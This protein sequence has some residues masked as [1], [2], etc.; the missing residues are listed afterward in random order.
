MDVLA[1]LPSHLTRHR[2]LGPK[3]T[4]AFLGVTTSQ[5]S[6]MR[7]EGIIPQPIHFSPR[8]YGWKVGILLDWVD[9]ETIRHRHGADQFT[10]DMV[11][12]ANE[13]RSWFSGHP[14]DIQ[15]LLNDSDVAVAVWQD[16]REPNGVGLMPIKGEDLLNAENRAL[17][18]TI[19][20]FPCGSAEHAEALM[21]RWAK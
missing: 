12:S 11:A 8:R 13:T 20:A 16:W 17:K 5:L 9:S 18:Y 15:I 1:N 7:S 14:S 3:A 19:A 4:A 21:G 2:M 10:V 6:R